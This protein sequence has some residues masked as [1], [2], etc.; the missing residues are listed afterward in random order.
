MIKSELIEKVA[1]ANPH[2]F[3]RDVELIVNVIFD[4]IVGALA[5]GKRVELRG[6]GAF[7]V[8]ERPARTGRNP[9]TGEQ[10]HV[11]AKV[12]PFFKTGKELRLRMNKH[13]ETNNVVKSAANAKTKANS[14]ASKSSSKAS[15]SKA[16]TATVNSSPKQAAANAKGNTKAKAA[17]AEKKNP[18]EVKSPKQAKAPAK[19]TAKAKASTKAKAPPKGRKAA[20]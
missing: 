7:S 12:V 19:A 17:A 13:S 15:S 18:A 6:F 11:E 3:Q 1:L 10:V 16:G 8:K 20:G 9:R 5:Q 14:K 4:E 2:L